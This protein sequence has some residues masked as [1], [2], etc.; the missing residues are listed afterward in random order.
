MEDV[1][2]LSHISVKIGLLIVALHYWLVQCWE[3]SEIW[4]FA[5][6]TLVSAVLYLIVFWHRE[7][8][9]GKFRWLIYY[10][11]HV[12]STSVSPYLLRPLG[13]GVFNRIILP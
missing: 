5:V 3:L 2:P 11:I 1:K 9:I 8:T 6:Q 4:T 13:D 12:L 10:L 7:K